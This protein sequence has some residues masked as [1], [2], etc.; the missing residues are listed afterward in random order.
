MIETNYCPLFER[1]NLHVD[2]IKF[3]IIVSLIDATF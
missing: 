2:K 1:V 3:T